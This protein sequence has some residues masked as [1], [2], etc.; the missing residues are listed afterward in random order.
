LAGALVQLLLENLIQQVDIE[1]HLGAGWSRKYC[2]LIAIHR[3][4]LVIHEAFALCSSTLNV[5]KLIGFG[6]CS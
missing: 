2:V 1:V 6:G 3:G 4:C 5:K